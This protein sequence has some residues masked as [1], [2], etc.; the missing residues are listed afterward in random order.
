MSGLSKLGASPPPSPPGYGDGGDGGASP[1]SSS[2]SGGSSIA[3]ASFFRSASAGSKAGRLRRSTKDVVR[4][5]LFGLGVS[6]H[7]PASAGIR[8][9]TRRDAL[10]ASRV[11]ARSRGYS[12]PP[13]IDGALPFLRSARQLVAVVFGGKTT[14]VWL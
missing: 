1:P 12:S 6:M 7:K 2:F 5:F 13:A 11:S 10:S 14:S 8:S 4:A 9:S 3:S